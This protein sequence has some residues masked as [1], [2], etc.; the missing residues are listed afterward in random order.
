VAG[1]DFTKL[2]ASGNAL[3][4][5]ATS[6][7]CVR[8]NVT[9]LIW[10]VKTNDGGLRDMNNTYS[11]YNPDSSTNGGSAGTQNGGTCSGGIDCDTASYVAA[12][13]TAGLCGASDWRMPTVEELRSIVDY[14]V[15]YPGSAIDTNYFP[16]AV[17]YGFWSASPYAGD[18]G[19]AWLCGYGVVGSDSKS[20]GSA[21]RLVRG[22][23][24]PPGSTVGN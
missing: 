12:V 18:T 15:S 2:D 14:A 17:N 19:S 9:G 6:W 1:F 5:S 24:V 20:N 23:Y 21:V 8:D 13:N 3:P 10:E 22:S 7:S 4:A 11:W 16:N